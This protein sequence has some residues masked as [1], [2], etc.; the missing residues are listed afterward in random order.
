MTSALKRSHLMRLNCQPLCQNC[1]RRCTS[2][3]KESEHWPFGKWPGKGYAKMN[4]E[5]DGRGERARELTAKIAT[6]QD[7]ETFS[8]LVKELNDLLEGVPG[9]D[10][11]PPSAGKA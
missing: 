5:G 3:L 2:I 7:P 10:K 9:T 8:L 1:V 6:E 4:L 11:T